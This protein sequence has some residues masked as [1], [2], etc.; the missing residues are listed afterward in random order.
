MFYRET[1]FKLTEYNARL[2][3]PSVFSEAFFNAYKKQE[4]VREFKT[5]KHKTNVSDLHDYNNVKNV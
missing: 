5:L 3:R 2:P 1:L 4:E